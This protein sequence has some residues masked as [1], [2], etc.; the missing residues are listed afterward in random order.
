MSI[1][2]MKHKT[3]FPFF[4]IFWSL[5]FYMS[6]ISV[7]AESSD[8]VF[9]NQ[10]TDLIIK[11]NKLLISRSY[12]LQI[13]NRQGE[14]YA[15]IEIPY[16][17]LSKVS[18]IEAYIKDKNGVI[19]RKLRSGD[20]KERSSVSD[21]SFYDDNFVKEF[22]LIHNVYPYTIFYSY[23]LQEESFFF[24][25]HWSPFFYKDVPTL[26][27][28]LT[29]DAPVDYKISFTSH[30]VGD[31][32]VDTVEARKK[33]TWKSS[34]LNQIETE[35][36]S[37]DN[38]LY[39]PEVIIVPDKFKFDQ[40]GSFSSW[41]TYGNWEFS[42][43]NGLND[44]P[45]NEKQ[46]IDVLIAGVKGKK[47]KI[48]V[49]YHYLQDATRYINI[50]IEKGGMKPYPASY[51]AIN[52]YGDCKA[53]SNYFKSVLSYIGIPSFYTNIHAGDRI[54][55]T[56]LNFPSMQFN[57]VILCVP[58]P[59]DTIW[60]DCTSDGPFN[61]L[62]TFTQNRQAFLI[63]SDNSHFA[64]TPF[65]T[66]EDVLDSRT[67]H[68]N[69]GT[70]GDLIANFHTVSRGESFESLSGLTRSASDSKTSQI[71][72][73]YLIESGFEMID[74][75]LIP[76]NRDSAFI[77]LDYTAKA[78]K[79]F[80]HYGNELLIPLIPFTIP[81]IKDPKNRKC[82]VQMDYPIYKKDTIL[83]QLPTGYQ[84]SSLPK[85]Q[86]INSKYGKYY[87]GFL[88]NKDNIE[89]VKSFVL[90]A[91]EYPLTEYN[92]F[93]RF[94]KQVYDIENSTYIVTKKQD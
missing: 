55:K 72:R 73:K 11:N 36:L 5:I 12:E 54:K 88:K 83:Y 22:T 67:I 25:D 56:D 7:Y 19:I 47:E 86:T 57:H 38:S 37:P 1:I 40:E 43:L 46:Q 82:P 59:N 33:Y 15:A 80:K 4:K 92:D 51:V 41:K 84:L 60:L 77:T 71:I 23:Q 14:E 44:L 16:S 50:S 49:L 89:V 85:N 76:S 31:M 69:S 91:G 17:K 94:V 68:V 24:I 78:D 53:L 64:Q 18:K 66:K 58:L 32:K 90:N 21:E 48:K 74:F 45:E 39:I 28:T 42:L 79:L 13:N 2:K 26:H 70:A 29:L 34:Y 87:I 3:D 9:L 65:M 52:K 75:K 61:Y 20:I 6:F 63:D 10:Q 62:G 93:Y 8:A 27:A 30:L 35:I 81:A